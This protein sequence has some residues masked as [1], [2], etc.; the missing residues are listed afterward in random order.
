[1]CTNKCQIGSVSCVACFCYRCHQLYHGQY[2]PEDLSY[3]ADKEMIRLDKCTRPKLNYFGNH[4]HDTIVDIRETIECRDKK[5]K[6]EDINNRSKLNV[7]EYN[8]G[9]PLHTNNR[10]IFN[11]T[12]P[13]RVQN[14]TEA[15]NWYKEHPCYD[16]PIRVH[17]PTYHKEPEPHWFS[18]SI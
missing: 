14:H 4:I 17:P 9:L 10:S 16:E 2:C 18:L 12:E 15:M 6:N 8:V 1:M 13:V 3:R 5:I 11:E 7:T